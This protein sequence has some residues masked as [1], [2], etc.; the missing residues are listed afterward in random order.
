MAQLVITDML[1]GHASFVQLDA[2]HDIPVLEQG[3]K[4]FPNDAPIHFALAT[5]YAVLSDHPNSLK[6]AE[7]AYGLAP[8]DENM[9]ILYA[10]ELK[11]NKQPAKAYQVQTA[12]L[13]ARPKDSRL[14]MG[15][16]ALAMQI[17]KYAE[18]AAILEP[19]VKTPSA[20]TTRSQ[21]SLLVY[22]LGS[23]Y[24]YEGKYDKAISAFQ[25][26]LKALPVMA[27]SYDGL[28]ETYLKTGDNEKAAEAFDKALSL[29]PNVAPTIYYRGVV[30]E[31]T[32]DSVSAQQNFNQAYTLLKDHLAKNSENGEDH[33][34]MYL[35]C[36]KLAKQD[37]AD[38]NKAEAAMLLYTYEAPW[39]AK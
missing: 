12:M 11:T 7:I 4:D 30:F 13:A 31:K 9:G 21:F 14:Q 25:V 39:K 6:H 19:L 26:S 36:Q 10:I 3:A 34:L 35:I 24:L 28:G 20:G 37:E 29:T 32:G 17:Q 2:P 38:A 22:M 15:E 27:G 18:A 1:A 8:T 16:V 5:C 23:C 33:Y